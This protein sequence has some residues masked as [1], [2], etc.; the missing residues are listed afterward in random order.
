MEKEFQEFGG[1]YVP[2][3]T[4]RISIPSVY[5]KFGRWFRIKQWFRNLFLKDRMNYP[6]P[7]GGFDVYCSGTPYFAVTK[8]K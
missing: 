4:Y 2:G 7:E 8:Q 5:C 1:H 6:V 3:V